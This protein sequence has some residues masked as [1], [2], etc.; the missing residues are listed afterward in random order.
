MKLPGW[1]PWAL[2]G[3]IVLLVALLAPADDRSLV[4]STY[5]RMPGGYAAWYAFLTREKIPA[6]RWQL[7][8]ERLPLAAH[9]LV[10]VTDAPLFMLN[11]SKQ[12]WIEEGNAL[13]VLGAPQGV[14]SKDGTLVAPGL[15][16]APAPDARLT[17]PQGLV[18]V[19]TRRRY[20]GSKTGR[21]LLA[22]RSGVVV[23]EQRLGRG[24]LIVAITPY[25]GANAY[26]D[27]AGNYRFLSALVQRPQ[28]PVLIDESIHGFRDQPPAEASGRPITSWVEYL[29]A[30]PPLLV[31]LV[32]LAVLIAAALWA[33]RRFGEPLGLPQPELQNTDAY[34]QALAAVL[35]KAKSQRF[36]FEQILRQERLQLARRLGLGEGADDDAVLAQSWSARTGRPGSELVAIFHQPLTRER[37][38]IPWL[39]RLRALYPPS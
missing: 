7:P 35:R 14:G 2:A 16:K 32:Q 6:Q 34:I 3:A 36:V 11:A 27:E 25:L 9:T 29:L 12:R 21:A 33:Q 19:E 37:D 26:Q 5:S 24:R 23:W 8:F 17:S 1:W 13:V 39:V 20:R 38:L 28:L 4:G 22:D 15:V 10:Q 18:R 31:A 30:I